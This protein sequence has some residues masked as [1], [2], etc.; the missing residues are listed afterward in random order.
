MLLSVEAGI[1]GS[2]TAPTGPVIERYGSGNPWPWDRFGCDG[3]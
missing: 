3:R 2:M 1:L